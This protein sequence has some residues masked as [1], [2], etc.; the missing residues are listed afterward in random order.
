MHFPD[1]SSLCLP[2]FDGC[3][4]LIAVGWLEPGHDFSLGDVPAEFVQ[5]LAE[6][7]VNPWQPSIFMG[8]HPCGFCRFSGGPGSMTVGGLHATTVDLGVSNLWV[9]A[10]GVVFVSPSLILHYIDAHGYAPPTEFQS[11]VMACPTMRSMDYLK[12][13]RSRGTRELWH[14]QNRIG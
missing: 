9:P 7:L 13:I 6:L 8:H 12:A 10:A 4:N 14:P 11:A 1:L 2:P 3:R 5:K